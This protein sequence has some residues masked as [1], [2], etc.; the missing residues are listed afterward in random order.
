MTSDFLPVRS[1]S[2]RKLALACASLLSLAASANGD[3]GSISAGKLRSLGE[4]AMMGRRYDEAAKYYRDAIDLEPEVAGNYYKLFRVHNR[5]RKLATALS[6]LTRALELE[7][8]NAEYRKQKARLLVSLGQCD[9]AVEDYKLVTSSHSGD[10][11]PEL[12][13]AVAE[14]TL[15]ANEVEMATQAYN[16]GDYQGSIHFFTAA[17][18]HMDQASD[19]LYMKAQAEYYV[20]DYY[21]TVSDTAKILKVHPKHIEAYQLRGEAY[22][23]L[24]EH[25]T[26]VTH[27]REGLKL[28]P[29][30][31]GCK[32]G[33][34]AVKSIQKKEKR[35][36]TAFEAGNHKD[37]IE[38][39]I[40]AM[41]LDPTHDAFIRP[42]LIKLVRAHSA[43]GQHD[44]AIARANEHLAGGESVEGKVALGD[45]LLT[46]EKFEDAVRVFREAV[47]MQP[48]DRLEE[49]RS[50]LKRAEVELKQSKEKNYYK[51]LGVPRNAQKKDIKKA[52][53]D[54][55]LKW[56]PDKVDPEMREKAEKKF[57]DISEANEVLS[58]DEMRAKFDRGEPVFENQGGQSQ[59]PFGGQ[60]QFFNQ[61]QH[62]GGGQRRHFR[63]H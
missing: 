14:A 25:D 11:S 41:Q 13:D 16:K 22:F 49:A 19:L 15:C 4:E 21:G 9:R 52:Y 58:D 60:N 39:W 30:H 35:G 34:K 20:G 12:A 38:H 5:Q 37:A 53:R 45:A 44:D 50:K 48:N 28:D 54:L 42:T 46:A 3:G 6:D 31:K 36:D 56:H 55:A 23:R 61:F 40:A 43:L 1:S 17:I 63:F 47:D 57:Q 32:A 8:T 62:G 33:H 2:I 29:E 59:N 51:I 27:F 18:S 10:S 24:G 26:A 7:P